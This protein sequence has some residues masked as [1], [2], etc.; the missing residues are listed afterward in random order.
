MNTAWTGLPGQNWIQIAARK[1][2]CSNHHR[3]GPLQAAYTGQIAAW[4]TF[5]RVVAWSLT[6]L[7]RKFQIVRKRTGCSS[8]GGSRLAGDCKFS[9]YR[10]EMAH[11][12]WCQA[13]QIDPV[14]GRHYPLRYGSAG[15]G[16][17]P[18]AKVSERVPCR[19]QTSVPDY[20]DWEESVAAILLLEG[21]DSALHEQIHVGKQL[22]HSEHSSH[23]YRDQQPEIPGILLILD[24]LDQ[25]F[26]NRRY[27]AHS[28]RKFH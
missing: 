7:E 15:W 21:K 3:L 2:A 9:C 1:V 13:S 12:H 4:E 28:G 11:L 10:A 17:R 23:D 5:G 8:S 26:P 20:V 16:A 19:R 22:Y 25:W 14:V 27:L 24:T 18:E 6:D